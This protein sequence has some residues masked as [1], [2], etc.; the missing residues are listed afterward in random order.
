M[1]HRQNSP[2]LLITQWQRGQ[3]EANHDAAQQGVMQ[4]IGEV[5]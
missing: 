1:H 4:R 2:L 3:I 5:P